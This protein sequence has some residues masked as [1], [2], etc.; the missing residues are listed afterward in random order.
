[1]V[2][3]K[4]DAEMEKSVVLRRKKRVNEIEEG[5]ERKSIEYIVWIWNKWMERK[6]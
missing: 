1:M 5:I 4:K 6:N 3:K 2:L